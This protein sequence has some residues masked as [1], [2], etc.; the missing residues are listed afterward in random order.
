MKPMDAA[1]KILK[2]EGMCVSCGEVKPL[3]EY[4]ECPPCVEQREYEDDKFPQVN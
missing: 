4:G 3:N 2:N 1:F